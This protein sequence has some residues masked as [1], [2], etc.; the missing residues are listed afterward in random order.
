MESCQFPSTYTVISGLSDD[1]NNSKQWNFVLWHYCIKATICH[2]MYIYNVY[3]ILYIYV[4]INANTILF[5]II[6]SHPSSRKLR[7]LSRVVLRKFIFE[8]D[9]SRENLQ[10]KYIDT[11]DII[12]VILTFLILL[13]FIEWYKFNL[14]FLNDVFYNDYF[15][16]TNNI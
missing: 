2:I 6:F 14:T 15:Q 4:C 9:V 10:T 13:Y 12:F 7:S 3:I 5:R 8:K 11:A 1:V 16:V